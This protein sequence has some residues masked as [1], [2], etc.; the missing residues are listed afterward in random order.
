MLR[1]VTFSKY[2]IVAVMIKKKKEP[3]LL[4]LWACNADAGQIC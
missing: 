2:K 4:S 1:N 3:K